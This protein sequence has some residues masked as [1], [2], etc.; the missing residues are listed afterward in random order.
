M[1]IVTFTARKVCYND[2]THHT[3]LLT[4]NISTLEK[5]SITN[6]SKVWSKQRSTHVD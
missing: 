5:Y 4:A 2:T 3:V 1:L 6:N